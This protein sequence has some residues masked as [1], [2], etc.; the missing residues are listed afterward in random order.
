MAPNTV[1]L[2]AVDLP[3]QRRQALADAAF[4]P[5][6]A[7]E[8]TATGFKKNSVAAT[9]DELLIALENVAV[10]GDLDTA[11]AAGDFA[12]AFIPVT[13][14]EIYVLVAAAAPA[15]VLND[16]LIL[17]ATGTFAKAA[18]QTGKEIKAKALEA[19]DNSGGGSEV[20]IKVRVL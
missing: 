6:A 12:Q 20:R 18:A 14:D 9:L 16:K 7:L 1:L 8:L 19:V 17:T 10:A 5:G 13:G 4:T 3:R 11:Y 15:I 2:T